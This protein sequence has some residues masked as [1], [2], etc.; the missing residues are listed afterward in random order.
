MKDTP[1][2]HIEPRALK[3][4][5]RFHPARSGDQPRKADVL[6]RPA[7]DIINPSIPVFFIG[8]NSDGLWVACDTDKRVGGIFLFKQSAVRF[9][10]SKS[11]APG[12]AKIFLTDILE[13]DGRNKDNR[14]VLWLRA[15]KRSLRKLVGNNDHSA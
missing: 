8:R 1:M 7:P 13:F 3:S 4:G 15:A 6:Q 11:P 9:A 14:F 12:C 10:D 2:K 5:H